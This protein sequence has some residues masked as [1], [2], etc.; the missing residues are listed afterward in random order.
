MKDVETLFGLLGLLERERKLRERAA[1]FPSGI[2]IQRR[3]GMTEYEYGLREAYETTMTVPG[4]N[5]LVRRS[6]LRMKLWS[7]CTA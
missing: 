4:G 2:Q 1:R 7:C 5:G 3:S 6:T